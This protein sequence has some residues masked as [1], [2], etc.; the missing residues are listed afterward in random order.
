MSH[1]QRGDKLTVHYTGMFEDGTIF[2]SS[3]G[4]E[5]LV[6]IVD[7]NDLIEGFE[8]AVCSMQ[9]GEEKTV[10]LEPE[11]AYGERDEDLIIELPLSEIPGKIELQPGKELELI[12]EDEQ[13]MLVVVTEL[14]E[15]SVI[16]D[17]NPPLAGKSLVF[18]LELLA[19]E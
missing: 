15:N 16:L 17:G 14:K 5:P 3:V 19:I 7:D 2:D 12:D 18:E 13:L 4:D 1:P 11:S 10:T 9:I 8:K 6:F